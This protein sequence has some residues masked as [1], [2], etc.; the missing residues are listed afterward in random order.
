MWTAVPGGAGQGPYRGV[1][2]RHKALPGSEE[3]GAG[4]AQDELGG[5]GEGEAEGAGGGEGGGERGREAVGGG[6][7]LGGAEEQTEPGRPA[8]NRGR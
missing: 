5:S 6:L 4:E 1:P 8:E 2:G 3:G 7:A